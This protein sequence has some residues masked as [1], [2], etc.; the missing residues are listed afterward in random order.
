[1]KNLSFFISIFFASVLVC[2]SQVEEK[3]NGNITLAAKNIIEQL[4]VKQGSRLVL[5]N[6]PNKTKVA[7]Q[8][9]A[10]SQIL[11]FC[12]TQFRSDMSQDSLDILSSLINEK[13]DDLFFIFLIDQS[14]AE[15]LFKYAGRPDMGLKIQKEK[16]FSDW[17]ISEEQFIRINSI[18]MDE[19][20]VYQKKLSGQLNTVDTIHISTRSGTDISFIARNWVTDKGEV[21]CTPVETE[22]NGII[23]VDGCAYWGPPVRP[24]KLIIC[25][26]RVVNTDEL[27][28]ADKQER[29][30]KDDLTADEN[31]SFVAEVGIG[32]NKNALWKSDLME[33]EQS[34]G[35]C[36]FGFGMN[37]NYG[38]QIESKKHLDLVVLDPTIMI[39]KTLVYKN[40][41]MMK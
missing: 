14:D 35:T 41:I 9:K 10:E 36:H 31:A 37:L 24:V 29:W 33:S 21:F 16:L 3:N 25:N 15:F 1:M 28:E 6:S 19:N 27:S 26:G 11:D 32:T 5:V 8:I 38:G 30:I 34:R 13:S 39:N 22:T 23:V 20:A 7:D 17:L 4:G 2:N 40:G 12:L 18:D